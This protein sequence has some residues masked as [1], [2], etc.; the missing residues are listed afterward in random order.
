M[1]IVANVMLVSQLYSDF[2]FIFLS[3]ME[4]RAAQ[5]AREAAE[6]GDR[7]EYMSTFM[8]ECVYACAYMCICVCISAYIYIYMHAYI[9]AYRERER[10][11]KRKVQSPA[12]N[13]LDTHLCLHLQ[14]SNMHVR[15]G[16]CS[17]RPRREGGCCSIGSQHCVSRHS[18]AS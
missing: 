3:Q 5:T 6:P 4:G 11:R 14:V 18:T 8:Y 13:G 2:I 17:E 1:R 16:E 10:E 12:R 9:Y 15:A 7:S